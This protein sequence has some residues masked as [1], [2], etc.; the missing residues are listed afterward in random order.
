MKNKLIVIIFMLIFLNVFTYMSISLEIEKTINLP[1]NKD[2]KK[3]NEDDWDIIVDDDGNTG[4][5]SIQKAIDDAQIGYHILVKTGTYNSFTIDKNDIKINGED[6]ANTFINGSGKGAVKEKITNRKP[7]VYE[8][9]SAFF[10]K[11]KK[12]EDII[13][14]K[15]DNVEISNFTIKDSKDFGSGIKVTGNNSLIENN[16][17]NNC[18]YGIYLPFSLENTIYNNSFFDIAFWGIEFDSSSYNTV[19]NNN[20]INTYNA[21]F[22]DSSSYNQIYCNNIS[23]SR[24]GIRLIDSDFNQIYDNNLSSCGILIRGSWYSDYHS[25]NIY[26]NF[27]DGVPIRYYKN[28]SNFIV[29]HDTSQV[30]L[31]NC[32]KVEISNIDFVDIDSCIQSC[33]SNLINITNNKFENSTYPAIFL[34]YSYSNNISNNSFN[35]NQEQAIYL[36]D[37]HHNVISNNNFYKN[38]RATFVI[39]P[40][41]IMSITSYNLISN[42]TIDTNYYKGIYSVRGD[43]NIFE[44]NTIKNNYDFGMEF[45]NCVDS[46]IRNNIIDTTIISDAVYIE[47]SSSINISNNII[48][49]S[50]YSGLYLYG[51]EN[52]KIYNNEIEL[53]PEGILL[54]E[55]DNTIISRNKIKENSLNGIMIVKSQKNQIHLNNISNNEVGLSLW[56]RS[57]YNKISNNNFFENNLKNAIFYNSRKNTWDSNYWDDWVGL[58]IKILRFMPK[59][60]PAGIFGIRLRCDFD[61]SPRLTLYNITE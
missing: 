8:N 38:G 44:Y 32:E 43:Y 4:Y 28:S 58:K 30:I 22:E 34:K 17:F 60:I 54:K 19:C 37:S 27:I 31:A 45:K 39:T 36:D 12:V 49:N 41:I 40:T 6:K 1:D 5:T 9:R 47:T 26:D 48:K 2:I 3:Y 11:E 42:N 57:N 20:F 50:G 25:H 18:Y 46:I 7:I 10:K 59:R 16:E 53:N 51:S 14:I 13:I 55:A 29:P 52:C 24:A 33:S 23:K 21:V 35:N 15:S 56:R 61:N